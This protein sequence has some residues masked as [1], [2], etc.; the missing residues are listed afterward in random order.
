[1]SRVRQGIRRG[2]GDFGVSLVASRSG[3]PRICSPS[4]HTSGPYRRTVW[5]PTLP[6][7]KE[8]CVWRRAE[9]P[10][11]IT[12]ETV[13][14]LNVAHARLADRE[15]VQGSS[16]QSGLSP[17]RARIFGWGAYPADPLG[18]GGFGEGS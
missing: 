8:Y 14:R 4:L 17:A 1:M 13:S 12:N 3:A 18:S 2:L 5:V 16:D 9:K 7:F 11:H 10:A 15:T 6:L